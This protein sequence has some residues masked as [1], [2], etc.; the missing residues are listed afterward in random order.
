MNFFKNFVL[1]GIIVGIMGACGA[2]TSSE[3][4]SSSTPDVMGY[5]EYEKVMF[6]FVQQNRLQLA[7]EAAQGRGTHLD[8]VASVLACSGK[9]KTEL[10]SEL[11]GKYPEIFGSASDIDLSRSL[12]ARHCQGSFAEG[13]PIA[14][15]VL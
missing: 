13:S 7:E 2:T 4:T 8:T 1:P 12:L 10:I 15:T 14:G 9:Q 5:Q 3:F 11:Q 6:A